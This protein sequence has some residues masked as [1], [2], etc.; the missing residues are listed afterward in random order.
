[1][2]SSANMLILGFCGMLGMLIPLMSGLFLILHASGSIARSKR[3]D[4]SGSPCRTPRWTLKG[5]LRTP[6]MAIL[7]VAC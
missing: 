2:V 5:V 3:G 7:V 6:F 4:E 1:M